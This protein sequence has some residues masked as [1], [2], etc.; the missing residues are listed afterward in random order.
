VLEAT[1]WNDFAG[2]R[3]RLAETAAAIRA[4][5]IQSSGQESTAVPE[6][7]ED[8]FAE[9]KVL[10]RAHRS[11]ERNRTLVHRAKR[12]ALMKTGRLA[13]QVCGFDFGQRYGQ[14]GNGFIECHHIVPI[15]TISPNSKTKVADLALL[16]S[17]C[18]WMVHRRRPWLSMD[19]M[20]TL[21]LQSSPV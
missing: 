19:E 9:G 14:L 21:L 5:L 3:A 16:C 4:R 15:S 18:H 20:R 6:A 2:D 12:L 11:R 13:C 7:E 1:V 17:N 10:F 8:E